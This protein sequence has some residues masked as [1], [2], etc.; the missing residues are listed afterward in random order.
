MSSD[1][2]STRLSLRAAAT[3]ARILQAA[4]LCFSERGLAA[5]SMRQIAASAGVTQPLVHHYF[6]AKDALFDAVLDAAVADYEASQSEQWRRP[7]GDLQFFTTGLVVLFQWIGEKPELLRLMMWARL[8]ERDPTSEPMRA[9]YGRVRERF[10][11]AKQQGII[12]ADID[13]DM[14]MLLID[15]AFKGYWDRRPSYESYPVGFDT[16]DRRYLEQTLR[17]VLRGMLTPGAFAEAEALMRELSEG[18]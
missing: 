12:Q 17:I 8:A 11:H 13:V 1:S 15:A 3:K 5:T 4:R 2:R 9:M 6:G 16:L 7:M 10:E 14:A 18:S